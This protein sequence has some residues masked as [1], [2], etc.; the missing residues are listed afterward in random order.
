MNDID[1]LEEDIQRV[2]TKYWAYFKTPVAASMLRM[3]DK[4]VKIIK[5]Q[6]QTIEGL[7]NGKESS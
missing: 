4:L 2:K 7:G 6:Q 5:L 3:V 1:E